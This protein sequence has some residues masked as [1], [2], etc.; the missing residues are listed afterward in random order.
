MRG[1]LLVRLV[2]L[3]PMA[4]LARAL[5]FAPILLC[6]LAGAGVAQTFRGTILGNVTDQTGA[7]VGQAKVTIRNTDTGQTRETLTT[8]DGSYRAPEL[9]LGMYT[10]TVEK[11]GFKTSVTKGIK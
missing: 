8:E 10:V 4:T 2:R 11:T 7:A 1:K 5:W 6:L 3:L 9:S